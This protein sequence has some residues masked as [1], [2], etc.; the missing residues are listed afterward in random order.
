MK[1]RGTWE[2]KKRYGMDE[3]VENAT[4]RHGMSGHVESW[5]NK[6][7]CMCMSVVWCTILLA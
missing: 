5:K 3:E 1:S 6:N 2:K 4:G 7:L